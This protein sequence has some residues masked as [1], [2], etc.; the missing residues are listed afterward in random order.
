MYRSYHPK[1]LTVHN[2]TF[3]NRDSSDSATALGSVMNIYQVRFAAVT[4][5]AMLYLPTN[6]GMTTVD[7]FPKQCHMHQDRESQIKSTMSFLVR[8]S[9]KSGT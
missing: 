6:N 4:L 5:D 8:C 2:Q 1:P 9:W 7:V 3:V